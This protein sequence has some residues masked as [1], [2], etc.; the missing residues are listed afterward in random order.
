MNM[1]G[2]NKQDLN[3]ENRRHLAKQ[4]VAWPT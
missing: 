1:D 2:Q 3:T 4:H